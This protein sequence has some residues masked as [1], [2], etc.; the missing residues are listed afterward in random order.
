MRRIS[1]LA[2]FFYKYIFIPLAIA[3][4][5]FIAKQVLQS[6][7]EDTRLI[8]GILIAACIITTTLLYLICGRNKRVYLEGRTLHLSNYRDAI[9]IDIS[10][11][12]SVS[13]TILLSPEVVWFKLRN[14][15][16]FGSTIYFM[17]KAR[18]HTGFTKHPIV[19][20]LRDLCKEQAGFGSIIKGDM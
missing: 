17:P 6:P 15:T 20:E 3:I 8:I 19:Q 1:S 4:Y 10:E 13:G 2:T 18:F 16:I 14:P 5:W 11:I 9:Q 12:E 7:S